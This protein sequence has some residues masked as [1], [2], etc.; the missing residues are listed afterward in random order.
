MAQR[1]N[2]R[3][4]RANPTGFGVSSAP[5]GLGKLEALLDRVVS[6][7]GGVVMPDLSLAG[8]YSDKT[9]DRQ[10]ARQASSLLPCYYDPRIGRWLPS[11]WRQLRAGDSI[12][13]RYV[14]CGEDR[15]T[16]HGW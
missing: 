11:N 16:E 1:R 9:R 8:R 3:R 7:P 6:V 4:T 5:N 15:Q 2:R 14:Q 13:Y 10:A 12:L